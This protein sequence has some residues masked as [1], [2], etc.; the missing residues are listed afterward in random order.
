MRRGRQLRRRE[1]VRHRSP[2]VAL[3]AVATMAAVVASALPAQA[4]VEVVNARSGIWMYERPATSRGEVR[5]T[6][7]L[8][9]LK[10]GEA[11]LLR[12]ESSV[13]EGT[14]DRNAVGQKIT[15]ERADG[16][17]VQETWGGTNLLAREG[18]TTVVVRQL[19][20]APADGTYLCRLRVYVNSHYPQPAK[21]RLY[22]AFLGD[23]LGRLAPADRALT[24]RAGGAVYFPSTDTVARGVLQVAGYR[25]PAGATR[26]TARADVFLTNCYGGGGAGCPLGTFPRTGSATYSVSASLVPTNPAC[27]ARRL[28]AFRTFDYLVH[29]SGQHYDLV[30]YLPAGVDCGTWASRVIVRRLTG[31]PFVVQLY[32]Y[33][34]ASLVAD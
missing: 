7:P 32:P 19:F 16:S 34:H 21:V 8:E 14:P 24:S 26:V 20:V 6:L 18:R 25:P 1:R 28:I 15:C 29:H 31:L 22:G 12:A 4:Y 33:S 2:A 10:A 27:R 11:R 30:S 23:V 5:A 13:G 9:D 17:S 3:T